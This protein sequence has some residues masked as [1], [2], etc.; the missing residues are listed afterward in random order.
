MVSGALDSVRAIIVRCATQL[1]LKN[2][3]MNTYLIELLVDGVHQ[4]ARWSAFGEQQAIVQAFLSC[5]QQGARKIEVV[6]VS[7]IK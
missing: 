6:G 4:T 1:I 5:G 3:K 2:N 7:L